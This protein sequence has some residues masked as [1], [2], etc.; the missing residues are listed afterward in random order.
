VISSMTKYR[1]YVSLLGGLGIVSLVCLLL[2]IPMVNF[3]LLALFTPGGIAM[4]TLPWHTNWISISA[5][6]GANVAIYSILVFA[7]LLLRFRTIG[8]AKLGQI[9]SRMVL[10]VAAISCLACFPSLNPLWPRGMTELSRQE[11]EL[12]TAL[13]LHMR[14]Q[15]A[16]S[17]LMAKGI[18]AVDFVENSEGVVFQGPDKRITAHAGD[19]VLSGRSQTSAS[20]FPCSYEIQVVLVFG[21][22]ETLEERYV[23][24]FPICP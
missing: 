13:P 7:V 18:E 24:R 8:L 3:F 21:P 11:S 22:D 14:L 1:F 15:D 4:S 17:M 12:Q 9:A 16:R 10:P 5:L 2:N 19:R 23:R 6:L 20:S